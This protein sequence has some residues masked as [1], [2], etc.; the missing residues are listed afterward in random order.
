ML[1]AFLLRCVS[2]LASAL[3][4]AP[5]LAIVGEAGADA[6][7]EARSVMVLKRSGRTAGFCTGVV[8]SERIVLTAAH[9]VSG[10]ADTKLHW[11]GANGAPVVVD[12]DH[13][14]VHPEYRANAP[15][16]RERSVDLAVV[17]AATPLPS[18]FS[19]AALSNRPTLSLGEDVRIGGFGVTAEGAG[20][21]SG[22]FRAA[23]LSVRAP[24]SRLLGW[25]ESGDGRPLGACT[26]DSGGP[27]I[28]ATGEVVGIIAWSSG[29]GRRGCGGVTQSIL[30]APQRGWIDRT[31]AG[32]E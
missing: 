16:T 3:A 1:S 28:D 17:R 25:A 15:R 2:I 13:V 12:V 29:Q 14:A 32:W 6:R 27:M 5:A 24:L 26:G 10:P 4:P 19:F 31:T 30:V 21:T 7:L 20:E 11:R 23:E 8:L 22:V 9:C 18:R